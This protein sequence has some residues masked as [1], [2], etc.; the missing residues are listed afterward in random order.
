[1]NR[2]DKTYVQSCADWLD[3]DQ[4]TDV[5]EHIH[6]T[7]PSL[8]SCYPNDVKMVARQ[9]YP[10]VREKRIAPISSED[11]ARV[12]QFRIEEAIA[13]LVAAQKWLSKVRNPSD[14][15]GM[16]IRD[17]GIIVDQLQGVKR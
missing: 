3:A 16:A 4:I 9:M 8:D 17:I 1:M 7:W 14:T 2:F 5:Y 11:M 6:A 10:E 13:S 12:N 15:V